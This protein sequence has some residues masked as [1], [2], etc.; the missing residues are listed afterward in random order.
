QNDKVSYDD[1]GGTIIQAEVDGVM[2]LGVTN[3]IFRK[4]P[5][6]YTTVPLVADIDVS[7]I[8]DRHFPDV[9]FDAKLAGAIHSVGVHGTVSL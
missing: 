9:T 1:E 3:K 5:A 8:A 4:D 6:P 7:D 2:R